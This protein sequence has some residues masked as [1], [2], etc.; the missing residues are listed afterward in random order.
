VDYPEFVKAWLMAVSILAL[1]GFY[2]WTQQRGMSL[3]EQVSHLPSSD[4]IFVIADGAVVKKIAGEAGGEEAEYREFVE[5]TGFDYR[6]DLERLVAVIG[7]PHSYYVVKGKFDWAKISSYVGSCVKGVCSM[8]ASQ[9]GKWI[10]LMQLSSGTVA[11]AVSP[12]QLAVGE[13]EASR[14]PVVEWSEAPFLV[15]GRG[16]HFARWGLSGE[17]MVEARLSEGA[18][19]LKAG[20][21]TRKLPLGKIFE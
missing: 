7:E 2:F 13:M 17:E 6:R 12:K 14:K 11:I 1:G 3:A 8:P 4:G 20:A 10:S 19:E 5:K 21:V 16:R 15:R 9:P 18:I